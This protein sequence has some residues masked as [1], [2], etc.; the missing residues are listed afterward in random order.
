MVIKATIAG[1][2]LGPFWPVP[3]ELSLSTDTEIFQIY[4]N[5]KLYRICKF[6]CVQCEMQGNWSYGTWSLHYVYCHATHNQAELSGN[7]RIFFYH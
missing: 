3:M 1:D 5:L 7:P 4:F 6:R 2:L